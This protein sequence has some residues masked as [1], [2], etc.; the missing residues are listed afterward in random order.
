MSIATDIETLACCHKGSIL[1]PVVETTAQQRF[2]K[3]YIN[4]VEIAQMLGVTRAAVMYARKRGI[5]PEPIVVNN[6]QIFVWERAAVTP[7]VDAWH[8]TI[9]RRTVGFRK[10]VA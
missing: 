8:N 4:S 9:K 3:H 5:L 10:Q 2:D 6:C 7:Y 1:A